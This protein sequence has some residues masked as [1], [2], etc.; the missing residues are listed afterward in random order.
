MSSHSLR[1]GYSSFFTQDCIDSRRS[2]CS[3][4]KMKCLR[5]ASWSGLMT[6]EPFVVA[7]AT[8]LSSVRWSVEAAGAAR[9]SGQ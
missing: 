4:L 8:G 6:L 7:V 5:P 2:S 1:C 3:W 9:Q